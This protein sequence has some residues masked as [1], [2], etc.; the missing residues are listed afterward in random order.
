MTP[1]VDLLVARGITHRVVSY[2]H[3]PAAAS[4]G[5][6]AAEVLG[7]DQTVVFKTLMVSFERDGRSQ[8]GVGVIPVAE[9]LNLKAI[10]KALGTKKVAMADPAAAERSS[11]YL[12]GGISPLGQ[13][14]VLPTVIDESAKALDEM[15][16]S[17]GKRGLE[18]ALAP[19][20]LI[21]LLEATVAPIAAG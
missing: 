2:D 9:K 12:V 15:H 11:G 6:E 4:Y 18:V 1:A 20:D 3:D 14:R 10:A 19:T 7:L 13:K 5:L 16:V 8:L 21:N 17:A